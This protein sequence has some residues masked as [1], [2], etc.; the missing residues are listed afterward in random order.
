MKLR[1][2]LYVVCNVIVKIKAA[3][4]QMK[5][6]NFTYK[7]SIQEKEVGDKMGTTENLSAP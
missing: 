1:I 4:V 5:N 6:I 7:S 2:L 3:S